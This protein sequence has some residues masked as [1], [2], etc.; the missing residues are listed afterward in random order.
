LKLPRVEL[1][2]SSSVKRFIARWPQTEA[3]SGVC[4]VRHERPGLRCAPS[5]LCLLKSI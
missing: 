1:G 2:L 5:G 4:F 3:K